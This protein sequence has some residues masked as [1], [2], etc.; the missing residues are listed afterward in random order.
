MSELVC[1][2]KL[3]QHKSMTVQG[4][5][6]TTPKPK[7]LV[8]CAGQPDDS[9]FHRVYDCPCIPRSFELDET[10]R[11]AD[12]ARTKAHSCP[13]FWFRGLPPRGWY[14]ELPVAGDPFVED[15]GSLHIMGGHVFTD[16]SRGAET[17]DPRLRSCGYG[18]AW[19]FS[20]GGLLNYAGRKS[21]HSAWQESVGCKSRTPRCSRSPSVVQKGYAA[22]FSSGPIVCSSST[23]S[24][25]G[26]G[27]NT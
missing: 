12:E 27:G 9:M 10:D 24:P 22:G 19:I 14:P 8:P 7:L 16:G 21:R 13:I 18:V 3:P 20:D 4:S 26:D 1:C 25:E 23:V 15:F 17:R 11:I 2:T 5:V 6:S